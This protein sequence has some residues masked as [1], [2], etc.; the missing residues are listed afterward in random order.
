MLIL[1]VSCKEDQDTIIS[2]DL[3]GVD[4]FVMQQDANGNT[5]YIP[6]ASAPPRLGQSG[7]RLESDGTFIEYMPAPADGTLSV[8]G[9]WTTVD[10]QTFSVTIYPPQTTPYTY[11][12]LIST[13]TSTSLAARRLP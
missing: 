4:W 7:F 8:P 6:A 12:L 3:F 5:T 1:L 13:V 10:G 11:T 2:P 9:T